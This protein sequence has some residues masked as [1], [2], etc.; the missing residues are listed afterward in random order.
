MGEPV[1]TTALIGMAVAAAGTGVKYA[2]ERKKADQIG[3]IAAAARVKNEKL[4]R[5][6]TDAFERELGKLTPEEQ[7][8]K[9]N[10]ETL[11]RTQAYEAAARDTPPEMNIVKLTQDAP[12]I[13]KT[14][15]AKQLG[16]KLDSAR[17]QIKAQAKLAGMDQNSWLQNLGLT[18]TAEDVNMY[19][20]FVRGNQNAA[21]MDM[22]LTKNAPAFPLGDL[23]SAAGGAM[24]SVPASQPQGLTP[25][26]NDPTLYQTHQGLARPTDYLNWYNQIV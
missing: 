1:S 25:I 14:E 17:A 26:A 6:S 8:K 21:S 23:L 16:H 22:T 10:E 9:I 24:M 2:Q 3:D 15:A 11:K 7:Q 20:N 5:Q 4:R 19:S 13:V 12:A 18:R